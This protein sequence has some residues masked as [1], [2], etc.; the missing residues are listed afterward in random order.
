MFSCHNIEGIK[1]LTKTLLFGNSKYSH[2]VNLQILN[3]SIDFIIYS[4]NVL[5]NKKAQIIPPLFYEKQ[6]CN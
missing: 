2:E 1:H 3:A 5:N 4:K 6:V